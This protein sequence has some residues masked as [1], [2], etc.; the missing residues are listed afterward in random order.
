MDQKDIESMV[1]ELEVITNE[2]DRVQREI[3]RDIASKITSIQ[4]LIEC[5]PEDSAQEGGGMIPVKRE[6][7]EVI[8][9]KTVARVTV[10]DNGETLFDG[11]F[12]QQ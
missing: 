6:P 9:E 4:R 3:T 2:L 1:Q 5:L 8:M 11:L 7:R 12:D 10:R